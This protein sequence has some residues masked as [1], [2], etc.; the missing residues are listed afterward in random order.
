MCF[1][2]L[3]FEAANENTMFGAGISETAAQLIARIS[4]K[5][6]PSLQN[7]LP[8]I[9]P[10]HGP[11]EKQIIE[12]SGESN[13]GKTILLMELIALTVLP[14]TYG[15]KG[16]EAIVIDTNSNFS[17]S[18][19]LLRVL[20]KYILHNRIVA[21][22]DADTE[23]LHAATANVEE[24]VLETMKRI[25]IFTCYTADVFDVILA[26]S[27]AELLTTRDRISL[28]AIDSI[29]TFYW[30]ETAKIRMD[31]FLRQKLQILRSINQ[32]F[33]TV[34]AYTKPAHFGTKKT[35]N[36]DIRIELTEKGDGIHF[37][38]VCCCKESEGEATSS[39]CYLINIFGVEW[40][41]SSVK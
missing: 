25:W 13:V 19:V 5:N 20:E 21:H 10:R 2:L 38:A 9:L 41:R 37:Q 15:G 6:R 3:Y 8:E 34:C 14:V 36:V 30:S 31:T 29:A 35:E 18:S 28:I 32:K 1:L 40:L 17:A 4:S 24:L 26:S 27:I 11:Q 39:R 23:D 7:L 33:R 16:A 12:I 22:S